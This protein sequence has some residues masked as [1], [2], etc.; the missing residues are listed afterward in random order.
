MRI[1]LQDMR[2]AARQLSKSPGFTLAAVLTM[3]IGIGAN[4]ALFS[5]MD[6][7]VMHPLAVP[8]LDRVMAVAEEQDGRYHWVTLG[9]YEDW[10]RQSNSF[11][12]RRC[13]ISLA[14]V[15]ST[16]CLA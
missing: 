9:N 12:Q 11:A 3:T 7:V 15:R 10:S 2:Y 14:A 16:K 8:Q 6:A 1:V 4:T 5:S 13:C